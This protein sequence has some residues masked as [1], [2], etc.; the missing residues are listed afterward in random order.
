MFQLANRKLKRLPP[1]KFPSFVFPVCQVAK[2][3]V[4]IQI[5]AAAAT[6]AATDFKPNQGE[7]AIF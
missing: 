5:I 4:P 2:K 1:E 3:T 7:I 6:A